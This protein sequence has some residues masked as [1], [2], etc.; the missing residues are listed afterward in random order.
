MRK[1]F[2]LTL[3]LAF[4]A[5]TAFAQ[6][7]YQEFTTGQNPGNLN[8]EDAEYPLGGGLPAG[9]S[10]IL[11]GG[12]TTPTWSGSQTIPFSFSFNGAAE[13]Q[14]K[15]SST[16]ILTF[17]VAS[18]TPAPAPNAASLPSASIP[19]KSVVVWG[20]QGSGGNDN[21]V[22]K[23]FGAAGSQQHWVFFSSYSVPASA[24]WTYWAIV[25]EEGSNNIYIV[26]MRH[27]NVT[28]AATLGIQIDGSTAIEVGGSPNIAPYSLSNDPTS[29][30][31][32]YFAFFPGQ[33][34][35]NDISV[36][37][38]DLDRYLITSGG[39]FDITGELE[40]FGSQPLT[41]FNL[42]YSV[43]GGAAVSAPISNV[44]V[45]SLG[46]YTYTHPTQWSPTA[47]SYTLNVWTDSPNGQADADPSSDTATIVVDVIDNFFPRKPLFETFT[48]STC[49]PCNPGNANFHQ[50][51]T[52]KDG[53]YV[54]IKYQQ[55]FPGAG[56][57]YGTDE[58][59]NRRAFYAINAIPALVI[60]GTF[61]T[62]S[63]AFTVGMHEA[64]KAIPAFMDIKVEYEIDEANQRVD[65]EI[66]IDALNDFGQVELYVAI[67]E[68][69]TFNNTATNGET[70]F[71]QVM[72]KMVPDE[73]GQTI[74][75]NAATNFTMTDAYSFNGSYR[76]PANY[77]GRVNHAIEHTVEEFSD[78]YVVA[79]VQDPATNTVFQAAVGTEG[80]NVGVEQP[81]L[82]SRFDLVPN[83]AQSQANLYF[84]IEETKDLNI[85]LFNNMGQLV[86]SVAN[87][88]FAA[89]EHTVNINLSGVAA[90]VYFVRIMGD[91]IATTKRLAVVK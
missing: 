40:N 37:T 28:L 32:R 20:I 13:T 68:N 38:V 33:R 1:I 80:I 12:N 60:D 55:N 22:T 62:N 61:E 51:L 46:S 36:N 89:G 79:W 83:P 29:A 2:T 50:Q 69:Q 75:V 77:A 21:V 19:N 18:A 58:A 88:S 87:Q 65:Y 17:D 15:V 67:L 72:K 59:V 74:T 52:G 49:G 43:N 73:N 7:F 44:N 85:D 48:S 34:P 25:L 11:G 10:P 45:A 8:T 82:I 14:Y 84:S 70:E 86:S 56:D 27:F 71:E 24:G 23:T 90:G 26:D 78:L 66:E 81:E 41:S 31:N 16:G 76:L 3:L 54:S 9:W 35:D 5:S 47:G 6:Y 42:N 64:A 30:D 63:N 53:E 57:P 4:A 39:P 91:G